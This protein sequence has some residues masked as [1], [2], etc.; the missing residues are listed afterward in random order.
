MAELRGADGVQADAEVIGRQI[1]EAMAIKHFGDALIGGDASTVT[2]AQ[3]VSYYDDL[4]ATIPDD[5][6]LP[7]LAMRH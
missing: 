5:R 6:A 4:S 3:F 2:T 1:S 7:R